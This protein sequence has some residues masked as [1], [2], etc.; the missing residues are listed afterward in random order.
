VERHSFSI[1]GPIRQLTGGT[2][3][4]V[5]HLGCFRPWPN[6]RL[7]LSRMRQL[8]FPEVHERVL[9]RETDD[10]ILSCRR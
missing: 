10:S 8:R 5:R 9:S 2:R 4:N 7:A 3:L 6:D 1:S